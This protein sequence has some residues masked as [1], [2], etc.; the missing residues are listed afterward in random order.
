MYIGGSK[1]GLVSYLMYIGHIR[2]RQCVSPVSILGG[3]GC[4]SLLKDI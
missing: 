4:E 3:D 1:T 2:R